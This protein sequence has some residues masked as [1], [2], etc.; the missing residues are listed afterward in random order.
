MPISEEYDT[1]RTRIANRLF[2]QYGFSMA[3]AEQI[4]NKVVDRVAAT[5]GGGLWTEYFNYGE[6]LASKYTTLRDFYGA[7]NSYSFKIGKN[8]LRNLVKKFKTQGAIEAVNSFVKQYTHPQVTSLRDSFK[9]IYTGVKNSKIALQLQLKQNYQQLKQRKTVGLAVL[10]T[11]MAALAAPHAILKV[12]FGLFGAVST[13]T[14]GNE[15]TIGVI[16]LGGMG[17]DS[18][19][20]VQ[21]IEVAHSNKIVKFRAVG[22]IFLASQIG[23]RDAIKISG[24]FTGEFRMYWLTALWFLTLASQGYLEAFD[25]DSELVN[26]IGSNADMAQGM[27]RDGAGQ[28][29]VLG[30]INNVV[31]QKP[32]YEK[33]MTYPVVTSHEILPNCYIETFSFEETVEGNKDVITYDLLLRTYE[34]PEE[35]LAD[36]EHTMFRAKKRTK[37]EQ[38]INFALNFGYRMLKYVKESLFVDTNSWKVENYYNVDALDIGFTFGLALMGGL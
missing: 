4:A 12:L 31:T 34:E 20:S 3:K 35:F 8:D 28:L 7:L 19:V 24:K 15:V 5:S 32:A 2:Y 16:P 30:K 25:F 37:T 10:R 6:H 27:F 1:W 26:Q 38:V 11:K 18:P 21:N 17:I 13:L 22:S 33:H 14:V 23:G 9:K 29:K 36:N